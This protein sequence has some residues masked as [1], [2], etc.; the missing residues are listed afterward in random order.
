MAQYL[1]TNVL[2]IENDL[3]LSEIETHLDDMVS[4]FMDAQ[5]CDCDGDKFI[6]NIN[7]KYIITDSISAPKKVAF[8]F[9]SSYLYYYRFGNQS[10][11][12]MNH[13]IAALVKSANLTNDDYQKI[14]KKFSPRICFTHWIQCDCNIGY[15]KRNLI[16][17]ITAA[18][19][20]T[21]I[22]CTFSKMFL[23]QCVLVRMLI[24]FLYIILMN[25]YHTRYNQPTNNEIDYDL[26]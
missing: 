2:Y 16:D 5:T 24:L 22:D 15:K 9:F 26:D 18:K 13:I 3:I 14:F 23:F 19:I 25:E 11:V 20:I 4:E 8:I 10:Y 1:T 6:N 21:D 7:E 17:L 12:D